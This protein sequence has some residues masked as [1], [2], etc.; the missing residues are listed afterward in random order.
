MDMPYTGRV[1]AEDAKMGMISART[2]YFCVGLFLLVMLMV[3]PVWDSVMLFNNPAYEYLA[4]GRTYP[5]L[6]FIFC[7][8]ILVLYGLILVSFFKC[9]S[10]E[11]RTEQTLLTM[12]FL[13]TTMLA[14][15]L[16]LLSLPHTIF[17]ETLTQEV[18]THCGTGPLTAPLKNQWDKLHAL[19]SEPHCAQ[20]PSVED[21]SGYNYTVDNDTQATNALKYMELQYDCSG[22]CYHGAGI[23]NNTLLSAALK[24]VSNVTIKTGLEFLNERMIYP[25]PLFRPSH[26]RTSCSGMLAVTM[27]GTVGDLGQKLYYEG[28]ALLIVGLVI[29]FLKLF[30]ACVLTPYVPLYRKMP[31]GYDSTY[32]RNDGMSDAREIIL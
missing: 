19:R 15:V 8:S 13:F 3:V 10:V 32:V 31:Q 18:Y 26:A 5:L 20:Q 4:D 29:A 6:L 11:T 12:G 9:A 21:C 30:G 7:G 25:E 24:N 23:A 27:N 28:T 14:L 22:F 2:S 16:V 17:A 1:Y